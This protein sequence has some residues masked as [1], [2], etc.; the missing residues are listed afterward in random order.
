MLFKPKLIKLSQ[1]LRSDDSPRSR[2]TWARPTQAGLDL[3]G[4]ILKKVTGFGIGALGGGGLRSVGHFAL[5]LKNE[6]C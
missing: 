4:K 5:G 1:Q 2:D 6:R 3:K